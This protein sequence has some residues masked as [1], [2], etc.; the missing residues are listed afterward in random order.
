MPNPTLNRRYQKLIEEAPAPNLPSKVREALRKAAVRGA[1]AVGYVGAGT[2][3]FL[4]DQDGHFYF[5]EA[6]ARIQVEHPVT[7]MVT[8]I[9]LVIEQMRLAAGRRLRYRQEAIT[10]T[11]WAIECRIT[12]ED[13]YND[14]LPSIGRITTVD[15]PSGPGVRVDSGVYEGFE[16]SLYYDPLIAKLIVWGETRGHAILRMR[17]ALSEFKILGIKTNI[18]FH[19]RVMDL[20]SFIGGQIDTQFLE[21]QVFQPPRGLT[22][23]ARLA[24]LAAAAVSFRARQAAVA[25][26]AAT[27]ANHRSEPVNYWRLAARRGALTEQ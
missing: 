3:E 16:V 17:R 4:L 15:E 5:T 7:E 9:D 24:A 12:A 23:R 25:R 1:K 21:R 20:T 14:F 22:E 19:L 11:G 10:L 27:A 26:A 6:N 2:F 13:P 8:G 18:P